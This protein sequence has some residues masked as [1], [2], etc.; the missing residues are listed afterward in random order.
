MTARKT[1]TSKTRATSKNTTAKNTTAKKTTTDLS[2]ELK[3]MLDANGAAVDTP[4]ADTAADARVENNAT[5]PEA[6]A[7]K[8]VEKPEEQAKK[9]EPKKEE[10]KPKK[11]K[12]LPRQITVAPEQWKADNKDDDV[13]L[14]EIP[15]PEG[16]VWKTV[17]KP[18]DGRWVVGASA[19]N[20]TMWHIIDL[21]AEDDTR[22]F[23]TLVHTKWMGGMQT[24]DPE[25]KAITCPWCLLRAVA[26]GMRTEAENDALK[27]K[28]IE[29]KKQ[30]QAE[31][32]AEKKKNEAVT[33][34]PAATAP[35]EA[36][37]P[38]ADATPKSQAA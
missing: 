8:T 23:C 19:T 37:K 1:N 32:R 14:V 10:P 11:Q 13:F 18:K 31:K 2:S 22:T 5:T 21:D 24:V 34:S 33:P 6:P 29:A 9:E 3:D 38:S 12:L 20:A 30:A 4:V 17:R 15:R 7:E 25:T 26:L 27:Q 36:P 28:E 35:E 16:N